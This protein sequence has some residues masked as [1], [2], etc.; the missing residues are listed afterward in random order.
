[1][2]ATYSIRRLPVRMK[3]STYS[4]RSSTSLNSQEVASERRRGV[5]A[6]EQA[7]IEPVAL[8]CR[9]NTGR[10]QN[11]AHQRRRHVDPELTQLPEIRT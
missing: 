10:L 4:R 2:Q 9:R 3:T 6:Q 8:R 11:V 1:M 5:R 7:P